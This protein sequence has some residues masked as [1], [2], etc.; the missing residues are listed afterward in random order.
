MSVTVGAGPKEGAWINGYHPRTNAILIDG[1]EVPCWLSLYYYC[2]LSNLVWVLKMK[3]GQ[4]KKDV[5]VKRPGF[6]LVM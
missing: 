4:I 5:T 1:G 6:N 3:C 2:E